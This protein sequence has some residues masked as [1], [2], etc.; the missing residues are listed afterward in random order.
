[1]KY[2]CSKTLDYMHEKNRM[3]DTHS[4]IGCDCCE[5]GNNGCCNLIEKTTQEHIDIVQKW[6]DEHP[7]LTRIEKFKEL[8]K[9]TEFEDMF[10]CSFGWPEERHEESKKA[11]AWW[12][13]LCN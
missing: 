8:I 7:E 3:C 5:L 1:M 11:E 12:N 13:K 9:D 4:E 2:D 6:S 10:D